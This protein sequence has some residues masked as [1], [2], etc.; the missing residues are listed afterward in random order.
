MSYVWPDQRDRFGLLAAALEVAARD[1]V[2]V[3][4]AGAAEWAERALAERRPGVATVL[5]H[6]IVVQYLTPEEGEALHAAIVAA[7]TRATSDAPF[8]WLFLEPGG[9]KTDVRLTLWPLDAFRRAKRRG[10]WRAPATTRARSSGSRRQ[11][12]SR[13]AGPRTTRRA[14]AAPA[15]SPAWPAARRAT[16]RCPA[17]R[18]RRSW[19]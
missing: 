4:R 16:R 8:A 10:C 9:D 17:R 3:E 5:F 7:G 13:E 14:G 11:A 1:E 6:S 12:L 2:E 15:R 18:A 19:A